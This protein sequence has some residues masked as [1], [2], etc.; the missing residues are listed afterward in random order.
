LDWAELTLREEPD[1]RGALL[2]KTV[3]A[4]HLGQMEKARATLRQ[5]IE[6]QPGITIARWSAIWLRVFSPEKMEIYVE[7]L[8]KAGLPEE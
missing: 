6:P 5:W 2:H 4:A 1:Y 8:R 7:G 3:A